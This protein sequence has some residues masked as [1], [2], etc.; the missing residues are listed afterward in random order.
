[1]DHCLQI[2][3]HDDDHHRLGDDDH[4]AFG[5]DDHPGF[6]GDDNDAAANDDD[7][8]SNDDDD[9]AAHD[10]DD[11]AAV[12]PHHLPAFMTVDRWRVAL[13][14]GTAR[15]YASANHARPPRRP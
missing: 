12:H 2:G 1:D 6:W 11:A 4:P 13:E 5:D 10:D 15:A 8:T 9:S 14:R 7:K 3:S